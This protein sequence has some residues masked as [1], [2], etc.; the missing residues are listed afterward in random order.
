[1]S[2]RPLSVTVVFFVLERDYSV[3]SILKFQLMKLIF[4]IDSINLNFCILFYACLML[5][6]REKDEASH[7]GDVIETLGVSLL[8]SRA[9][10]RFWLILSS[11]WPFEGDDII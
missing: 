10:I 2:S 7:N 5:C 4:Q 8:Y 1:M 11:R 9:I 6:E 3:Y